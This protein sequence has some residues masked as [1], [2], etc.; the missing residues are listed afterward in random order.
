MKILL[1]EDDKAIS[2]FITRGLGEEGFAT[3][4]TY[5]GDDGLQLALQN[6][7][8]LVILDIM[9]PGKDGFEVCR[10]LRQTKASIPIL[11]LTGKREAA[12]V[13]KGLNTGADDYL[14]KP[15]AFEILTA[16]IQA[17]LRRAAQ[18][19]HVVLRVGP[20]VLNRTTRQV[21]YEQALLELSAKEYAIMEFLML[22]P[23]MLVTRTMLEQ[24]IWNQEFE[25]AS[26]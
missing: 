15:F 22:H 11:M 2:S 5:N 10:R 13:V 20:L 3:D 26:K 23:D 8:D 4:A 21:T 16:R 9:L 25:G 19:I 7:Y 6:D 1:I 24:N 12:D 17:L 14:I 18:P